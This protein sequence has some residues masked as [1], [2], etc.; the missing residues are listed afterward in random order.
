MCTPNYQ[1]LIYRIS[2]TF[3][4]LLFSSMISAQVKL[5]PINLGSTSFLDGKAGPGLLTQLTYSQFNANRFYDKSKRVPGNNSI[6]VNSL[7]LL[8]ARITD[9]QIFGGYYGAEFV[10]PLV[11]IDPTTDFGLNRS[12]S[13]FGDLAISPFIIQWPRK[14]V[15]G[16]ST[17]QR[18]NLLFKTPTGHYDKDADVNPGDNIFSFNPYYSITLLWNSRLASS[19]RF[20]YLW[21]SKNNDPDPTLA[22]DNTQSGQALHFNYALSYQIHPEW[23]I[24]F[25]GYYLK[26]ITDDK[27]DNVSVSRSREQVFGVGPGF[28]YSNKN[29]SVRLNYYFESNVENRPRGNKLNLVLSKAF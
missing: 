21:S 16:I 23:R 1:R 2:L 13:G 26:Q 17:Y 28:R 6:E 5:P 14:T 7:V 24:G 22:N 11:N 12:S 9:K 29:F 15:F 18:L 4:C 25:S 10:L 8:M 20:Y 27:V 3:F 19:F